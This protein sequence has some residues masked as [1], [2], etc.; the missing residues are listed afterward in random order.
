VPPRPPGQR[1]WLTA[2]VAALIAVAVLLLVLFLPRYLLSWDLA[3]SPARPADRAGAVN[4]I[5]SVL[6][7]GLAGLA[8]LAGAVFTWRQLQVSRQGQV[9]DRY[10]RAIEQLGKDSP[11]LRV[12]AIYALERIA[13]DSATDRLTISEVL[14]TFIRLHA[15]LSP[16]TDE[17][18]RPPDPAA[19]LAAVRDMTR[20][21]P[22]RDRGP[23][24]QAAITV[25]GRLAGVDRR[26]RGWLARVDLAGSDLGYSDLAGA[27]LHYSDLSQSF[28]LGADLR[29]ADLTGVWFVRAT[30]DEARLHQADLR[31]AVFWKARLIGADLRAADLTAADLTGARLRG[32]RFDLADLRG[33]DFTTADVAGA[34]FAGA[35]A[36][37]T[38][39]WPDGFDPQQAGVLPAGTAPPIR[40]QSYSEDP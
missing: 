20:A 13:R 2:A 1:S 31:S 9:T 37:D 26:S 5:R 34:T 35:V 27:D 8:V 4:A 39:T 30:L 24:I 32:A 3:G 22:L 21:G 29:R 28:L 36:D 10:T 19:K 7:Q 11:V 18:E 23:H 40:P 25:L 38:T 12:G 6:M 14:T 16:G 15:A 33:A 17:R